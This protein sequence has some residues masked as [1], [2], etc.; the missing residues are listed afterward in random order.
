MNR[1]APDLNTI[2]G[3]LKAERQRLGKSQAALA[4][5]ASVTKN[6]VIGWEQ[7][8]ASPNANALSAWTLAGVDVLYVVTGERTLPASSPEP[9]AGVT[10]RHALAMLDP[11][12]RHRL[13]L[14]LLAAELAG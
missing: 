1:P 14:D 12:D 4:E 9:L 7:G 6:T 5:L 2:G 13:L 10:V 11:V 8:A 3:R